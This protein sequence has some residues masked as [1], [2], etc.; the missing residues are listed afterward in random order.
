MQIFILGKTKSGKSSLAAKLK[1]C[2]FE[3]YEAGSWARN[4]FSKINKDVSDEMSIIFKNNLT[5]YALSIL[6]TNPL[7]SF[8]KYIEFRNNN[9][10]LKNIVISGVRNPDDFIRMIEQDDNN[11][12]LFLKSSKEYENGD[13][14]NFED[15]ISVIKA[16]IQW[17]QQFL[18]LDYLE[19]DENADFNDVLNDL[20]IKKLI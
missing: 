4:E 16:Y 2:D 9:K 11:L 17:K 19:I 8:E 10:N 5:N 1:T 14:T 7:Y 3:I 13:L 15:G 12:V 20:I 18:K 6:K